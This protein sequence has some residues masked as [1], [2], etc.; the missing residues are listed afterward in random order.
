[1]AADVPWMMSTGTQVNPRTPENVVVLGASP[2]EERYA[3]KAMKM[4]LEYGHQPIPVNPGFDEILGIKCFKSITD[5]PGPVDTVTL[6][7]GA[8]RSEPLMA[9]ILAAKPK[10]IIFNPGAENERLAE[11]ARARGI[12]A[13]EACT[14][15]L[16]RTGQY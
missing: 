7:L 6:Y 3:N 4:L 11:E 1:M 2:N 9:D 12:E 8:A 13:L 5:V 14:L 10:R 15:V 16:L